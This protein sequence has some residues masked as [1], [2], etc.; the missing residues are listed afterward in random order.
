MA[1]GLF[2]V[3]LAIRA[4]LANSNQQTMERL[5]TLQL[6]AETLDARD[7]YTESHSQR[8]ADLAARLGDALALNRREEIEQLR[9]A[10]AL[11]DL[12]KIGIRDDVL[13]KAEGLSAEE[14]GDHAASPPTSGRT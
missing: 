5:Q 10:G 12:G 11:H 9:T 1:L 14:L 2:G 7:P 6:A 8:V 3:L 4:N 13:N